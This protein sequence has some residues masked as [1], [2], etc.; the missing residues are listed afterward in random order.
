M[1]TRCAIGQRLF[2]GG[3]SSV[4]VIR[5]VFSLGRGTFVL[6]ATQVLKSKGVLRVNSGLSLFLVGTGVDCQANRPC[7]SF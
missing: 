6:V 3:E 2:L 7:V 5:Q 4:A 1:M